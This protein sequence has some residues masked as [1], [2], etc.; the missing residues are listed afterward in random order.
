MWEGRHLLRRLTYR[1]ESLCKSVQL[2]LATWKQ[3]FPPCIHCGARAY[4]A[5]AHISNLHT[6]LG[7]AFNSHSKEK[8]AGVPTSRRR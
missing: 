7:A 8:G 5:E 2:G 4:C 6:D 3:C 1:N